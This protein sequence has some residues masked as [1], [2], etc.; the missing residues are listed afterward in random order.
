MKS[1]N[2]DM[3]LPAGLR[4][5][6]SNSNGNILV[7]L[8]GMMA[9]ISVMVFQFTSTASLYLEEVQSV[10]KIRGRNF[11]MAQTQK[12]LS[13]T[14]S[15]AES[16]RFLPLNNPLRACLEGGPD[17]T[18]TENCCQGGVEQGFY[19]KDPLDTAAQIENKRNLSGPANAPVYYKADGSICNPSLLGN[20]G[21]CV[22]GLISTFIAQCPGS[23]STCDHAEH[24]EIKVLMKPR[25]EFSRI[26][27]KPYFAYYFPKVNYPPVMPVLGD[28][29]LKV[30]I[31]QTIPVTGDSGH[32]SEVQNFKFEQ[33][34][35]GDA[36]IVKV[37]CQAFLGGV[38]QIV[39]EPLAPGTTT[40]TLQLN[41]G[42]L[43][44]FLSKPYT[45]NVAVTL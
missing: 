33:C 18:C 40:V 30:S 44:N 11:A 28:Q 34:V 37:T 8:L 25:D 19:F 39:L 9:F 7:Y 23:A 31:P 43:T 3:A 16:A 20:L 26:K 15:L 29:A 41:D 4:N 22:Y 2:I 17:A 35:S 10:K 14:K 5:T 38:G 12:M 21:G 32:P 36:S 13:T 45:F 24:L 6:T 1:D 27:E 42:G